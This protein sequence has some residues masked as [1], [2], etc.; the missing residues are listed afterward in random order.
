M[1][2]YKE[3]LDN[4][5]LKI[6]YELDKNARMSYSDIAKKVN[7]S[8]Q[9]VKQRLER[10]ISGGIISVITPIINM[11]SFGVIPNQAFLSLNLPSEEKKKELID[12]LMNMPSIAQI[13][14]CEGAYDII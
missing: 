11:S 2:N 5:D 14:E 7:V 1:L 9:T 6:L 4:L 8:K 3:L 12:Y 13:A 10:L